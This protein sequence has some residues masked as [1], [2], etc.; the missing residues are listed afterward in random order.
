M[1]RARE[2]GESASY[3]FTF[4]RQIKGPPFPDTIKILEELSKAVAE[5]VQRAL[6]G[7]DFEQPDA[8]HPYDYGNTKRRRSHYGVYHLGVRQKGQDRDTMRVAVELRG[9]D[10]G[11][12]SPYLRAQLRAQREHGLKS[13]ERISLHIFWAARLEAPQPVPIEKSLDMQGAADQPEGGTSSAQDDGPKIRP[14][15]DPEMQGLESA[16]TDDELAPV[17]LRLRRVSY[18]SVELLLNNDALTDR[19]GSVCRF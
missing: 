19:D 2:P 18:S 10:H 12:D 3:G 8:K 15:K 5:A 7:Y 11:D 9:G 1:F 17:R 16:E 13:N 6:P 14:A 4:L